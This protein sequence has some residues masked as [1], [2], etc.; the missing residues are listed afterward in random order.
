MNEH[1]DYIQ[2]KII[3]VIKKNRISTTEVADCLGKT[4]ALHHVIPLNKKHFQ[5]GKI[6]LAYGYNESN[7]EIHEQI[8]NVNEGDIVIVETHNCNDRAVFGELVSKYLILYKGVSAIVVNGYIRDVHKIIKDNYPI[9]CKGVTP[10]GCYNEK[11][12]TELNPQIVSEW[13]KKYEGGIAVCD[14][15]GVVL[16]PPENPKPFSPHDVWSGRPFF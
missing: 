10:I 4:G 14:D 1:K 7:W 5:V 11:N 16:I 6:F 2:D 9:W 8:Q 13:K 15:G 12:G 3:K